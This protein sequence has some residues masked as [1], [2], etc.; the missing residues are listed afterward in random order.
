[1]VPENHL[2]YDFRDKSL[3]VSDQN[4]ECAA[5]LEMLDVL[6]S[7]RHS[8]DRI[9]WALNRLEHAPGRHIGLEVLSWN[10]IYKTANLAYV[11][12]L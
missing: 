5:S 12:F 1:M 2:T 9:D 4:S 7:R 10:S 3:Q 11:L 8:D 6:S